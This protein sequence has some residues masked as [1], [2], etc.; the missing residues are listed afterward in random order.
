MKKISV[1]NRSKLCCNSTLEDYSDFRIVMQ[2]GRG[3][4]GYFSHSSCRYP[5]A[6]VLQLL[7]RI[8]YLPGELFLPLLG[9]H[10]SSLLLIIAAASVICTLFAWKREQHNRPQP[11]FSN[12]PL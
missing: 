11:C 12:H 7:N 8:D 5:H 6:C 3:K 9:A 4:M 1:H 2:A 10:F